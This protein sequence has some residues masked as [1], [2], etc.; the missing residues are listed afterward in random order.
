MKDVSYLAELVTIITGIIALIP[1]VFRVK[2]YF[3]KYVE[4]RKLKR[5]NIYIF[6]A[7][8]AEKRFSINYEKSPNII[9]RTF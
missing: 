1:V 7:D 4:K 5:N 3:N 8:R 2:K 9:I 6:I